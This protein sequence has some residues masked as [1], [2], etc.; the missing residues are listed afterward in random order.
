MSGSVMNECVN[1]K[2]QKLKM[3]NIHVS[4][5]LGCAILPVIHT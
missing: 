5:T 3:R 2:T 1:V 4:H